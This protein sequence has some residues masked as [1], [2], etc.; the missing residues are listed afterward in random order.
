M[1]LKKNHNLK[2]YKKSTWVRLKKTTITKRG[3][4]YLYY[5]VKSSNNG[6]TGWVWHKYLTAGKYKAPVKKS[7]IKKIMT[8]T[9]AQS[10]K[11][12]NPDATYNAR[13]VVTDTI[14]LINQARNG[15]G[16]EELKS[17]EKL[18][19]VATERAPQL[20]RD[21]SHYDSNGDL[22]AKSMAQ[23]L[24]IWDSYY[25]GEDI[26]TG[27]FETTNMNLAKMFVDNYKNSTAHWNDLMNAS[28]TRIGVGVYKN[29]DGTVYNV[30]ELG[31]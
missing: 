15:K 31:F 7:I 6:A 1:K 18:T 23:Q 22:Y 29:A 8:K 28:D 30:I 16:R 20:V 4:K 14:N 5:Y 11:P 27:G 9:P 25:A 2:N 24:G 17:D 19:Q 26:T 13:T 10:V 12:V 3:K 21:F